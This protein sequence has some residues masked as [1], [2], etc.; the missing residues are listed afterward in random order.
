MTKAF[1]QA[2]PVRVFALLALLLVVGMQSVEAA[3]SHAADH[4]EV[5][6]L[7][8]DTCSLVS[9]STPLLPLIAAFQAAAP[10]NEAPVSAYQA[11]P[12]HYDSRGPPH[13]S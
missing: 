11:L 2:Q 12:R 1:H 13:S 7:L 6:C 9:V 10:V 5:E 4:G 3:H 8:C